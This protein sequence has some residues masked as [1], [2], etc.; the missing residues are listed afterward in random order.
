MQFILLC[1]VIL[2]AKY[3]SLVL[4]FFQCAIYLFVGICKEYYK[5]DKTQM[6]VFTCVNIEP[7]AFITHL[8]LNFCTKAS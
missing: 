4:N 7:N 1:Y 2:L 6:K 3:E 5:S 8:V